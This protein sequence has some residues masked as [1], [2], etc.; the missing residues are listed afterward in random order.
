MKQHRRATMSVVL[1]LAI[2]GSAG[3]NAWAAENLAGIVTER[4]TAEDQLSSKFRIN[5]ADPESTVPSMKER[6]AN[7]VE[8]GYYLQDM[9]V[10]AEAVRKAKDYTSLLRYRR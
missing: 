8:F 10:Q 5:D 1:L 3:E 4:L 6:N 9:L 7:P 2:G